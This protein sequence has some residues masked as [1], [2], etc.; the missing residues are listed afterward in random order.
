MYVKS[1][2]KKKNVCQ[3]ALT[4]YILCYCSAE[5]EKNASATCLNETINETRTNNVVIKAHE[6]IVELTKLIKPFFIQLDTDVTL[7]SNKPFI[8]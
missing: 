5:R 1:S 6:G 4:D 8:E 2:N 3:N 7:V